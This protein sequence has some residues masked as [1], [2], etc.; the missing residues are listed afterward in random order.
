MS[1]RG[2]HLV[3]GDRGFATGGGKLARLAAPAF[4]RVLEHI[5]QKLERG[6]LEVTLPNGSVRRIGFRAPGPSAAVRIKSWM[7]LLRLASSGSVGW[8]KAWT[9]GE[10]SSPDPVA[11]F[12]TFSANAVALGNVARA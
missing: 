7:A 6:G 12:E 11:I 10:W 3:L 2:E 1:T 8:Y 9:L 5:D 4:A